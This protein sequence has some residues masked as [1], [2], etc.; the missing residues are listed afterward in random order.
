MKNTAPMLD[1][2]IKT[3]ELHAD[4]GL[5]E[6][7]GELDLS[8]FW[9][10]GTS[11]ADTAHVKIDLTANPFRFRQTLNGQPQVTHAFDNAWVHGRQGAQQAIH[12]MKQNKPS[13]V[14]RFQGIDAPEL[15]YQPV[16]KGTADFRQILGETCTVQLAKNIKNGNGSHTIPCTVVSAVNHPGD[17]FDTYGR[18][19][20]DILIEQNGNTVNLN[21]WLVEHGWAYPTFYDSMT[22]EEIA[23][24]EALLA[25]A[26]QNGSGVYAHLTGDIQDLDWQLLFRSH[27]AVQNEPGGRN[28]L[29]PKMF[30]RLAA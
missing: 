30:R 17:V 12:G 9:P 2:S 6:V 27:G 18:L 5:L 19:V 3:K 21:H 25:K 14:I 16:E 24:Y 20:G 1:T 29:M 13:L 4:K 15:H 11:D 10:S 22:V 23:A 28:T 26:K 7:A 8:Q